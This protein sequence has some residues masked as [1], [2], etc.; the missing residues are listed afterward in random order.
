M[1]SQMGV[2]GSTTVDTVLVIHHAP[3]SIWVMLYRETS[4]QHHT[5]RVSKMLQDPTSSKKPH[6]RF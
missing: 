6:Q 5:Q 3:S 1:S 2:L 4:L